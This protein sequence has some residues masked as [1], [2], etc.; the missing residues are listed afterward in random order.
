MSAD[1]TKQTA[2]VD[3]GQ[4]YVCSAIGAHKVGIGTT[5]PQGVLDV[6][7]SIFQRGSVLHADYVFGTDYE[8]ESID[9]HSEFMWHHKHLAAIPETKVDENGREIIEV[10]AHRRG[11]VEELEKANIYIEQLHK[12]IKDLKR[13]N[14]TIEARLA[15]LEACAAKPT[16]SRQG[17]L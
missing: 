9:E 15:A 17:G 12:R 8:L 4:I 14:E 10:G 7:G 16:V 3:G 13:Q 11:I 5:N 6:N 2:V 1:G